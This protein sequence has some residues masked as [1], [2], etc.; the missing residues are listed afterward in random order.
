VSAPST[1][2]LLFDDAREVSVDARVHG[3]RVSIAPA[4]L[5]QALGWELKPE[6]LCRDATCVPVR[7]RTALVPDEADGGI[8]L[9]AFAAALGRPVAIEAEAGVAALGV[10]ANERASQLA[11]L[12]APDFELPDLDGRLHRLSEHR[13]KKVL[14]IAY[15]SW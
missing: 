5:R 14:L 11:T 4:A 13:G 2:F 9:E 15:A 8:D 1:S 7:D 12:E 3:G 6:G 10:A